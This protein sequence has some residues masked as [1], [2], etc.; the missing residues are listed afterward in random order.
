MLQGHEYPKLQERN[1]AFPIPMLPGVAV[2]AAWFSADKVARPHHRLLLHDADDDDDDWDDG[3]GGHQGPGTP[4]SY[5][6]R[7]LIM[8]RL[9]VIFYDL[10]MKFLEVCYWI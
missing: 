8:T 2:D 5:L 4:D 7:S 9:T 10:V 6:Y 3:D 1:N